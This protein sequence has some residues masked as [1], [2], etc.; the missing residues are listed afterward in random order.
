MSTEATIAGVAQKVTVGGGATAV[1]GGMSANELAALGG[2]VVAVIGLF[3]QW[4]YKRKAD[5]R[6]IELHAARLRDLRHE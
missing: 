2:L 1:I 5:K 6:E 3:V 4:Y